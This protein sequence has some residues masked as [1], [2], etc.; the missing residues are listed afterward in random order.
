MKRRILIA[1]ALCAA[2]V[3]GACGKE[4]PETEPAVTETAAATAAPEKPERAPEEI[5]DEMIRYYGSYGEEADDKVDELLKELYAADVRQGELWTEIMGYWSYAN[6][7]MVVNTGSLPDDLPKDDSLC[8]VVLGFELKPDGGMK[9]ELIGRLETALACAEQYPNA[10]VVCTGGG[11]AANNREAT[12]GGRM[13]DW[14]LEHGLA[15]E[16]LIVEDKSMTTAQ[17]AEFS[18]DILLSDH[19]QVN[20]VA[21]VSS[22]YHIPWGSLLFEAQFLKSASERQTPEIHVVSNCGYPITNDTYKVSE[23]LRWETGGMLQLVGDEERAMTYYR[24]EYEKP[25]L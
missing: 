14:M 7:D 5:I 2:L 10:Y 17:N 9:D 25:E 12:E 16:R 3:L 23:L 8:I 24:N 11:T 21:L 6:T 19:P 20:S 15:E 18:Y 1:S 22:S 13:G 4:E